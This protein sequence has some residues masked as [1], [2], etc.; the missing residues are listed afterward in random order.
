MLLHRLSQPVFFNLHNAR[1]PRAATIGR[2]RSVSVSK[3]N[4]VPLKYQVL[5][6]EARLAKEKAETE[7]EKAEKEKEKAKAEK[8]KQLLVC[9]LQWVTRELLWVQGK[10]NMRGLF[11]KSRTRIHRC[12]RCAMGAPVP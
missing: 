6:L 7:K 5:L 12:S 1:N 11:G 3:G 8:E 9:D 2:C 4:R 10:L